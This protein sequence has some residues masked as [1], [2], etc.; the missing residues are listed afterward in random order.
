MA[1]LL[2]VAGE[3]S[4][5]LHGARLV[6]ELR[7][8]R[9]ELRVFGL[10]SGRLRAA[11][12]DL[13]ADGAEISAVGLFEI[14]KIVRR[15]RQIFRQLVERA[16]RDR[17]RL[18]VL[19]DFPEFNLRLAR[20]LRAAG[21]RVAYYVSPQVW[22]WRR[23]RVRAIARDVDKMLVLFPFEVEFYRGH[24]MAVAH[25]GH[26]L[27]DEVPVQPQIWDGEPA[28]GPRTFKVALLPGSRGSEIRRLL[29]TML[30]AARLIGER[31]PASFQLLQ[32][33]TVDDQL[34][35]PFLAQAGIEV[36][37]VPGDE[38]RF[39]VLAN[40]HLALCASGTATLETGLVGTPL[41]VLY[42]LGIVTYAMARL[43]GRLRHVSLVNLVLGR[44]VVPELIQ[45]EAAPEKVAARA[46]ALLGDRQAIDRMRAGLGALRGRLGQSGAT[47]RVADEIERLLDEAPGR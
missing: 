11:G 21:V 42:R 29:P 14:L 41:L 17:P 43:L 39:T 35:A 18:A 31:I 3:A 36:E 1:D 33:P 25:V 38:S 12:V 32:A 30:K 27:V 4:G 13:V 16:R 37:V 22:A 15:A 24:D 7:R 8:R 46:I 9:P 23:G 10:G 5:D 19:I 47:A 28:S 45:G 6:E 2:V 20:E 26:P 34:L 44:D 40:C